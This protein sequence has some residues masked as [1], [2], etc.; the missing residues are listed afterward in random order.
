MGFK[1]KHVE[2]AKTTK[3]SLFAAVLAVNRKIKVR[4][5]LF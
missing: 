4:V 1:A 2:H 5:I 3:K